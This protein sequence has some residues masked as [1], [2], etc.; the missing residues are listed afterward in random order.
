MCEGE[1]YL[2]SAAYISLISLVQIGISFLQETQSWRFP[3]V[4]AAPES[5]SII[6]LPGS[7][8][9]SLALHTLLILMLKF[10]LEKG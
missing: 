7:K 6:G 3:R 5:G 9:R 10:T 8:V 1:G 4:W 2:Q